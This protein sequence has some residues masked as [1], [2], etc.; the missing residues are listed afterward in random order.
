MGGRGAGEPFFV[1]QNWLLVTLGSY[2]FD[3]MALQ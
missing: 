3:T 1:D 2:E